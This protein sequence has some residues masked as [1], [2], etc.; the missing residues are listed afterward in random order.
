M[1][2]KELQQ[3]MRERRAWLL[4]T[5][6][7][8]GLGAVVVI[9]YLATLDTSGGSRD[10]QGAEIGRTIFLAVTYTQM[11]VLLLLAPALSA[12]GITIEKEQRTMAGLLTSLLEP[13]DIWW[14]KFVSSILFL[15]VLEVSAL[16]ILSLSF[17]FGGVSPLE[18]LLVAGITLL[19]LASM[20][21]I[22]LWCSSFFRRSVHATDGRGV[23]NHGIVCG[24]ALRRFRSTAAL[25][26][27]SAAPES[28]LP[29][30]W[31]V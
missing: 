1:I 4:P 7:L 14:G 9:S 29:S 18:V 31:R 20:C 28:L 13:K 26:R 16:P 12:G 10:L 3:R 24:G 5:L 21:S 25:R 27:I 19:V 30:D 15:F 6:Y 8:L 11:G 22:G 17:V 2:R 23:R